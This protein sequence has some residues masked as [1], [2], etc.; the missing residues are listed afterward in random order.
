[1]DVMYVL[2]LY[3]MYLLYGY[4]CLVGW[5]PVGVVLNCIQ[6]RLFSVLPHLVT[7]MINGVFYRVCMLLVALHCWIISVYLY[8][9]GYFAM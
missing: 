2:Y 9:V 3:Y 4:L 1:M 7:Y 5:V 8:T 6:I